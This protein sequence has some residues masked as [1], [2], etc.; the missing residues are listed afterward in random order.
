[1]TDFIAANLCHHVSHM[2]AYRFSRRLV[3]RLL[4]LEPPFIAS[5]QLGEDVPRD[6]KVSA[7]AVKP[8]IIEAAMKPLESKCAP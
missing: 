7:S 5:M 6:S 1:M 4:S 8:E 3:N 2:V